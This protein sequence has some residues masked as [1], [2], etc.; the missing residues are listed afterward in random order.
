MGGA[1]GCLTM[2]AISIV[3]SILLTILANILIR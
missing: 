3:A 1:A 2:I